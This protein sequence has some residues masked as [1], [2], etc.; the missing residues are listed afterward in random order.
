MTAFC[1]SQAY[2]LDIA[3]R[4]VEQDIDQAK[5]KIALFGLLYQTPIFRRGQN[6]LYTDG[7]VCVQRCI[8]PDLNALDSGK[9]CL[10]QNQAFNIADSCGQKIGIDNPDGVTNILDAE[11]GINTAFARP[12]RAGKDEKNGSISLCDGHD[13]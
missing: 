11:V 12:V 8:Q 10:S 13:Q 1:H 2:T 7:L 5:L 9:V 3:L 4:R 6:G